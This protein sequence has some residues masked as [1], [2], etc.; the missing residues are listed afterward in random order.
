M[1]CAKMNF[2]GERMCRN[3]G[4]EIN[5]ETIV[6]FMRMMSVAIGLL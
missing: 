1:H 4:R 5:W 3:M 2:G 6:K